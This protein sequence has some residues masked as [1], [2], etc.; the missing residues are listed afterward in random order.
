MEQNKYIENSE[1]MCIA[2]IFFVINI[3]S[4]GSAKPYNC[5]LANFSS[6]VRRIAI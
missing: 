2:A 1:T 3:F 6:A 5:E 4:R